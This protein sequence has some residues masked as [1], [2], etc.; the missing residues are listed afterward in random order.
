MWYEGLAWAI[1][2]FVG[3]HTNWSLLVKP[4]CHSL[5]FDWIKI[6]GR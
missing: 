2:G 3:G 4:A 5:D 6:L 1:A